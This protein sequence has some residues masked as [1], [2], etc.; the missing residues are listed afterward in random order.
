MRFSSSDAATAPAPQPKYRKDYAPPAYWIDRVDL[1]F[2]LAP[3]GTRVSAKLA[4]RRNADA[5]ASAPLE[6]MGEDLRT[7]EVRLDGRTLE[8][9]EYQVEEE[10]LTI[11]NAPAEGVLETVVEID[12]VDN[13]QLS[14]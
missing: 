6:L 5:G 14:G 10:T 4:F 11:P 8:A 9:G 3:K 7:L 12:P 13:L 2:D 1:E